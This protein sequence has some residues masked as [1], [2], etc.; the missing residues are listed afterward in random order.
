MKIQ[1]GK[2]ILEIV[3]KYRKEKD[4]CS[5]HK[6]GWGGKKHFND[7]SMGLKSIE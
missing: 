6:F 5:C 3:V 1:I 4:K 7:C 2:S